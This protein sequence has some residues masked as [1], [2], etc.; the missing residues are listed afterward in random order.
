MGW[1]IEKANREIAREM[2]RIL[3]ED[4]KLIADVLGEIFTRRK[5]Q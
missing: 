1:N 3:Q 5:K 2:K 4:L